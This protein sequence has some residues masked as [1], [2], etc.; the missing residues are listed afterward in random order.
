M[1][2]H[3]RAL[4]LIGTYVVAAQVE[5]RRQ[6]KDRIAT[7]LVWV[8][9][10]LAVIPLVSL[11]WTTVARGVKVLDIYFLTHSMGIVADSQPGGGI[12][13][14]I[15]GSL[16]QVGLATV[17]GAPIGCS[18]RSTSWSTGAAVSLRPSRSSST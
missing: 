8:A 3:R 11:V 6:A 15:L 14:A 2:R 9:F 12:Y 10:L 13:H 16:E 18:P 4:F 1:G 7:S 5:G 17:I